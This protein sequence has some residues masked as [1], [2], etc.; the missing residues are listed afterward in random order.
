MAERNQNRFAREKL[1]RERILHFS[2]SRIV[3]NDSKKF[4]G[5]FDFG[6]C[7]DLNAFVRTNP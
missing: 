2:S 3:K 7:E 6:N 1:Q 5:G 4:D